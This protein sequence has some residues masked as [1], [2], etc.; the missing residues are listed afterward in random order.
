MKAWA[1]GPQ[2]ELMVKSVGK[3]VGRRT[4]EPRRRYFGK[5][6]KSEVFAREDRPDSLSEVDASSGIW[7]GAHG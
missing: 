5:L 3:E 6:R 7:L 1:K 4:A 2:P